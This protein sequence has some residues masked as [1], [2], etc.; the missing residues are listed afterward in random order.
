MAI[1]PNLLRKAN[2]I[3]RNFE[4]MRIRKARKQE[5]ENVRMIELFE[6][7]DENKKK[8]EAIQSMFLDVGL[9]TEISMLHDDPIDSALVKA[10]RIMLVAEL[11]IAQAIINCQPLIA[12][13][14]KAQV[15]DMS[16][17]YRTD[18]LLLLEF[19]HEPSLT[20]MKSFSETTLHTYQNE[21]SGDRYNGVPTG[22]CNYGVGLSIS[23]FTLKLYLNIYEF[24]PCVYESDGSSPCSVLIGSQ[25]KSDFHQKTIERIRTYIDELGQSDFAASEIL[26]NKRFN[27]LVEAVLEQEKTR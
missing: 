25:F 27:Y 14:K 26:R 21:Q 5:T 10:R 15:G 8:R 24:Y 4:N 18:I 11:G 2:Q 17:R 1:P 23:N 20:L 19:N 7:N 3:V 9:I 13:L 6:L 22:P 16:T 12:L